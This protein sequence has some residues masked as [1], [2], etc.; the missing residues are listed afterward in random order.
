LKKFILD[1][2]KLAGIENK[3]TMTQ[4]LIIIDIGILKNC[5]HNKYK[6]DFPTNEDEEAEEEKSPLDF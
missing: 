4:R 3:R 5:L 2:K 6:I 1:L